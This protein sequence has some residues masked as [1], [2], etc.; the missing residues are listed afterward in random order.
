LAIVDLTYLLKHSMNLKLIGENNMSHVKK[1]LTFG[2]SKPL[3]CYKHELTIEFLHDLS[4]GQ[5]NNEETYLIM[6][7]VN[8]Y[9]KWS[10]MV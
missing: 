6:K 1:C 3:A 5:A 8:A 9:F 10:T 4:H 7:D 2:T